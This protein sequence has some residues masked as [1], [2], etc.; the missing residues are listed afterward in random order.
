VSAQAL[1]RIADRLALGDCLRLGRGEEKTGG[2][3]KPAVLA[4]ACEAVIAAVHLDGGIDASRA[5]VRR[6]IQ[7]S[8]ARLRQPG[9]LTAITGDFK[10]ALQERLQARG[11]PPPSY[12]LIEALGPDHEKQFLIEVR[13]GDRL[14]GRAEG[15]SKK[16]AEQRAAR[17]GLERLDVPAVP[18]T[19][20]E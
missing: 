20:G 19:Q 9:Q 7:A 10:S 6:E 12:R 2:R 15:S 11:A 14:L 1:A 3:H 5:L 8:L 16:D 4:D 18:A 13:S 17:I